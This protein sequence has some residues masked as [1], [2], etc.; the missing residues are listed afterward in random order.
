[1]DHKPTP[2]FSRRP[3]LEAAVMNDLNQNDPARLAS[4]LASK[5]CHDLV[6]PLA[7]LHN[8]IELIEEG[9]AKIREEAMPIIAM[10]AR[11]ALARL[12][13]FR[14]AFGAMGSGYGDVALGDARKAAL[15]Y[16]QDD[17]R[18]RLVWPEASGLQWP[19]SQAKALLNLILIAKTALPRGGTL[20]VLLMAA[21]DIVKLQAEG[22]GVLLAHELREGLTETLPPEQLTGETCIAQYVW[23]LMQSAG[24]AIKIEEKPDHL[25]FILTTASAK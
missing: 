21:P 3:M 4:L 13:F 25:S 15:G 22:E 6:G 10:S 14:L 1:M 2:S 9:D 12:S 23:Y 20:R 24:L 11:E 5:L 19:K 17:S 16:F 8:G 18:L 7:A